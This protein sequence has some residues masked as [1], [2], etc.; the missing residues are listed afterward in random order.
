MG[1]VLIAIFDDEEID[2]NE[3]IL[4]LKKNSQVILMDDFSNNGLL[5]YGNIVIDSKSRTVK[6]GGTIIELTNYEFGILFLLARNPGQVFSKAQIY[7]QVWNAPYYGAEDNVMSLIR[8]IRK[9][10][11]PDPAKPVYI[12]TVWGIGYKFNNELK[13]K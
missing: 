9:K 10:I 11:E 5:D 7:N 1:K 8:R 3:L 6:V 2:I 4:F 12:L 13:R